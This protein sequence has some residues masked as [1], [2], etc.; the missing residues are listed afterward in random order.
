M[1]D[2]I[3][4]IRQLNL[5]YYLSDVCHALK[6]LH[7]EAGVPLVMTNHFLKE[8]SVKIHNDPQKVQAIMYNIYQ[9]LMV[10]AFQ[11]DFNQLDYNR[12]S[13]DV[14]IRSFISPEDRL[15]KVWSKLLRVRGDLF[16]GCETMKLYTTAQLQEAEAQGAHGVWER[17]QGLPNARVRPDGSVY[18]ASPLLSDDVSVMSS[19]ISSPTVDLPNVQNLLPLKGPSGTLMKTFSFPNSPLM[20]C[21]IRRASHEAELHRVIT[22][23]VKPEAK[24][25]LAQ[26]ILREPSLRGPGTFAGPTGNNCWINSVIVSLLIFPS[27]Y[28]MEQV[29]QNRVKKTH[30]L[31][32]T[33]S[34]YTSNSAEKE[35]R[36]NVF[37]KFL[38]RPV[39][40]D[41]QRMME[42]AVEQD[43]N[44]R[45]EAAALFEECY[46]VFHTAGADPNPVRDR[47]KQKM[48]ECKSMLETTA[49]EQITAYG[50]GNETH[51]ISFF[52]AVYEPPTNEVVFQKI[53]TRALIDSS[54]LT[55][56]ESKV[57]RSSILSVNVP[58]GQGGKTLLTYFAD[59]YRDR[60][61][62]SKGG[63]YTHLTK[64]FQSLKGHFFSFNVNR[65]Y[66][67]RDETGHLLGT[68]TDF[69]HEVIPERSFFSADGTEL[70]LL[71]VIV[72]HPGH[73]LC[74]VLDPCIQQ[75]RYFD[76]GDLNQI[77]GGY[78]QLLNVP[79]LGN[80][81]LSD[82]KYSGNTYIYGVPYVHH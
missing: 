73:V 20:H 31:D 18:Y 78:D 42:A 32:M 6:P 69:S 12:L 34:L 50:I 80:D 25:E 2:D 64:S 41:M 68:R 17:Y 70:F 19:N 45:R 38:S 59:Q 3:L 63:E 29:F 14:L 40:L 35:A 82:V 4:L 23:L 62:L 49:A 43:Y 79:N 66:N 28:V 51:V 65:G 8:L 16:M 48:S 33:K 61:E 72:H 15:V 13:Q 46:N 55:V 37:Y 44:K 11:Q 39:T 60:M 10:Y 76:G 74:Y 22:S 21:Q 30:Y 52:E 56:D 58:E 67:I 27:T 5:L 47:I 36:D 54:T 77:M 1:A 53:Y 9:Q 75:Y 57:E 71:S 24:E 26:V 81:Y 7:G